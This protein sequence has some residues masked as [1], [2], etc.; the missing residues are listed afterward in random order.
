MHKLFVRLFFALVVVSSCQ[1][2][3][4]NTNTTTIA[5]QSLDQDSLPPDFNYRT[6]NQVDFSIQLNAPDGSAIAGIPV[7]I[8][9]VINDTLSNLFVLMT[10]QSGLAEG[11]YNIPSSINEAVISPN[12]A[13]VPDDILV[14][15]TGSTVTLNVC[16]A[17]TSSNQPFQSWVRSSCR[18]QPAGINKTRSILHYAYLSSYNNQGVPNVMAS[19]GNVTGQMLTIYTH[20]DEKGTI[21]SEEGIRLYAYN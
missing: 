20:K 13:G 6:S 16:G 11:S 15:L 17:K 2:N 8:N 21:H 10:D 3:T 5:S 19:N 12:Y 7:K 4:E 9:Q 1:K 18:T 14:P